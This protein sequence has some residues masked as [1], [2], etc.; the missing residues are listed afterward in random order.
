MTEG[1]P[2]PAGRQRPLPV[3]HCPYC[4]DEDLTPYEEGWRCGACLRAFS[5]RL[6]AT[7]VQE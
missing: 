5:V 6:I 1:K 2:S 3:F 7:G 4:G